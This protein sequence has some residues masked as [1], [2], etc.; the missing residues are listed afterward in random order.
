[1]AIRDAARIAGQGFGL[2]VLDSATSLYRAALEST[3]NRQIKRS[4]TSQ[5]SELQEI[6]RRYNIPVVITNQVY[7]DID[8]GILRPV[9]GTSMEHLCKAILVLEKLGEGKRRMRVVKHR[10]QPEGEV[11]EFLITASG[12]I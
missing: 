6:A 5:I 3:D 11:A 9:G 2:V 12:L 10:S 7:M 4:L 1:M 8:T